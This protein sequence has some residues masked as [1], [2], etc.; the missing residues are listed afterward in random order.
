MQWILDRW[1]NPFRVHAEFRRHYGDA[2]ANKVMLLII[3]AH[4]EMFGENKRAA[5]I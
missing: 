1:K 3:E 2:Y 5:R 4:P